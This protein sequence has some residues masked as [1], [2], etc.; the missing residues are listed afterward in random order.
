MRQRQFEG[1][2]IRIVGLTVACGSA[3]VQ[4]CWN[5]ETYTHLIIEFRLQFDLPLGFRHGNEYFASLSDYCWIDSWDGDLCQVPWG[6]RHVSWV[7]I[8]TIVW[9]CPWDCPAMT[10]LWDMPLK[11]WSRSSVADI[12][13]L[14]HGFHLENRQ[15]HSLTKAGIWIHN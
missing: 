9:S 12:I 3:E 8:L 14:L 13:A 11:R 10:R 6:P 15:C 4:Y 7:W 5:K 1:H 2:S